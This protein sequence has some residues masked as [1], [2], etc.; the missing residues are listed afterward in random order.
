[1]YITLNYELLACIYDG[2]IYTYKSPSMNN[3]QICT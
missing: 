3:G 2:Y 1:M